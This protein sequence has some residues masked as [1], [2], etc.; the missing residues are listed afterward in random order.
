VNLI[1]YIFFITAGPIAPLF[2][3]RG[4]HFGQKGNYKAK[5]QLAFDEQI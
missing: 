4:P 5:R 2:Q 3:S 1:K